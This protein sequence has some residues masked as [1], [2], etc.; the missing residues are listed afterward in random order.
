MKQ[1]NE[2][3]YP[4]NFD[5]LPDKI[6]L[7]HGTDYY[8]LMDIL[9]DGTIDARNGKQ[10]G[11]TKGMNW[12]FTSYKDNYSRG[13]LFSIDIDKNELNKSTDGL[14]FM[15]NNEIAGYEP[16]DINSHNFK[17]ID[18]FDI[19]VEDLIQNLWPKCMKQTNDIYDAILL[20][21]DK[22]SKFSSAQE[23]DI[24]IDNEII[25][26][27][28]K[29]IVGENVL[30]Q[31]CL[32][33]GKLIENPDTAI[34]PNGGCIFYNESQAMP[35]IISKDF[36][37]CY[38]G[39]GAWTHDDIV[40][41]NDK[42]EEVYVMDDLGLNR[43]NSWCGRLWLQDKVVSIWNIPSPQELLKIIE[44]LSYDIPD[45]DF[46]TWYLDINEDEPILIDEYINNEEENEDIIQFDNTLLHLKNGEDKSND[47]QMQAYLKSRSKNQGDKLG[48]PNNKREVPTAEY[49][50]YKKYGM[51]ESKINE[52]SVN[53]INLKSFEVQDELHPKIWIN[54]KLNS[55]VRLRLLD[56]ADDFIDT[57]AVDWVKPKDIVFTGSLANYNWSRYSDIDIHIVLDYDKVYKKREFV[58]DYF[59]AKK[60]IWLNEHPKLKIYGFPVEMYVE[61]VNNEAVSSGVYSLYKNQWIEQPTD[62]E[63]VKL[64]EKYIKQK[65][66][67]IMNQIDKIEKIQI[68]TKDNHKIESCRNKLK[69]IFDRLKKMRKES[70]SKHGEMSSGN[71]IYKILRRTKYID[72]IWDLMNTSYD[73]INSLSE[74]KIIIVTESQKKL[75]KEAYWKS[76]MSSRNVWFDGEPD[77]PAPY[78]G[79]WIQ[80]KPLE[81][82]LCVGTATDGM[83]EGYILINPNAEQDMN[84]FSRFIEKNV[85]LNQDKD[86]ADGYNYFYLDNRYAKYNIYDEYKGTYYDI[87]FN[88]INDEF[89]ASKREQYLAKCFVVGDDIIAHHNSNYKITD[90]YIKATSNKNHYSKQTDWGAYFWLGKENG[91]DQSNN[92]QY[93]YYC[94]I[95]IAEIYF[96]D[97]SKLSNS[98]VKKDDILKEY[99]YIAGDWE[100]GDTVVCQTYK[101][102]PIYCIKALENGQ[103][104][105][106]D[107]QWNL[108]EKPSIID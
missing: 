59:G 75:L 32:I 50:F 95:P 15:N 65:A 8:G 66:A 13:F 94:K 18:A 10:T 30:R 100:A 70:L 44:L 73:K 5:N 25:L 58:E 49:N 96:I 92:S 6:T 1:I 108:I 61:D 62:F 72:K 102:T 28:L 89:R 56:I 43:S 21:V 36:S 12:F 63:D 41:Y 42:E 99:P 68:S 88:G 16:I 53:D 11:E 83:R 98:S 29:Q 79:K 84:D 57:L 93:T 76:T 81:N 104:K 105:W 64:N 60:E 54:D 17:I 19:H 91:F 40:T 101:P 52:V 87:I 23:Y 90:E 3:Y 67:D 69:N 78:G 35:F 45:E 27:I 106:Y 9:L 97:A 37:E 22:I 48:I 71:I 39:G 2:W 33:E 74:N 34:S 82:W 77:K 26:Q 55:R 46:Y 80:I 4:D 20:F 107:P 86:G 24:S 38:L 31:E 47:P 14:R 51:G 7:Y 85:S 103:I